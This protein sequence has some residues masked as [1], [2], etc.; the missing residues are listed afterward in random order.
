MEATL[1]NKTWRL[2]CMTGGLD[3][4]LYLQIGGRGAGGRV[5]HR[6]SDTNWANVGDTCWCL[7]LSHASQYLTA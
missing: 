1:I 7:H 4:G 6:L 3:Q 2:I 5:T